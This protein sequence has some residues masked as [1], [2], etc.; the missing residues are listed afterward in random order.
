MTNRR[1]VRELKAWLER[2]IAECARGEARFVSFGQHPTA[3][4]IHNA[5]CAYRD[6]LVV[7]TG[8]KE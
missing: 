6:T 5:G 3:R 1:R 8:E 4:A 2:R 7:L